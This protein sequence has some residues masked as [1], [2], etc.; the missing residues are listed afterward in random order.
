MRRDYVVPM[1]CEWDRGGCSARRGC[2]IKIGTSSL[3]LHKYELL[4]EGSAYTDRTVYVD[5]SVSNLMF[6]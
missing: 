6:V 2:N 5:I 1:V 4:R 3:R